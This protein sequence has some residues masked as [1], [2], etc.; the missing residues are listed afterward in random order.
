MAWTFYRSTDASAPALSGTAGSLITLLDAILVNGYGSQPAAGW[1]KAF[2]GTNK[3][4][5]RNGA[6]ARARHYLRVDDSAAGGGGAKE[7]QVRG[8]ESMSD[9]D[10]GT[11][12]YPTAGQIGGSGLYVR[13]S[14][15]ADATARV[16][17]AVADDRTLLLFVYTADTASVALGLYFG[18]F[19]SFNAADS[20]QSILIA[21]TAANAGT[22]VGE[23]V[24]AHTSFA[25]LSGHYVARTQSGV[26]KSI[27]AGKL[28]SIFTA[29]NF[30]IGGNLSFPNPCDGGL[31]LSRY[32]LI[33][34]AE[35]G[36]QVRGY[37]RGLWMPLHPVGTF[38]ENYVI[39]GTGELAGKTFY[40]VTSLTNQNSSGAGQVALET[41]NTVGAS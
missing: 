30:A 17:V 28:T 31:Y 41:S 8:Y 2:S 3:A 1:T 11:D 16:W 29:A 34:A 7:A 9:V 10:T 18:E 12:P 25:T 35:V 4:A 21:R 14:L 13:K 38:Q 19:Y 32:F 27:A 23:F 33:T 6:A 37:L 24:A 26:T 22:Y 40:L 15:T 5:Y 39:N 20:Y 36:N